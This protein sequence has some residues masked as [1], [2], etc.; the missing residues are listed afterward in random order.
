MTTVLHRGFLVLAALPEGCD[1]VAE[2]RAL[3]TSHVTIPWSWS[4]TAD[5]LDIGSETQPS[6]LLGVHQDRGALAWEVG[7]NTWVP[8]IGTNSDWVTYHFGGAEETGLPPFSE[9][10]I[11]TV[12][13]VL[14]EFIVT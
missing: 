9:V 13:Q 6:L 1:L 8:T 12:Y 2:V 7:W 10:P 5:P 4:I 11:D 3:Y 14:T